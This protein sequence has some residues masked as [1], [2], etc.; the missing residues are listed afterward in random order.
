MTYKL[1]LRK[2]LSLVVVT[3]LAFSFTSVATAETDEKQT[4]ASADALYSEDVYNQKGNMSETKYEQLAED[5]NAQLKECKEEVD[6][7]KYGLEN[8]EE[9]SNLIRNILSGEL[10][11]CFHIS[12]QFSI[13]AVG[14]YIASIVPQY[15]YTKSQY[16][17]MLRE[18]ETKA[19]ELLSGIKD[20]DSLT[21]EEKLLIIH[22]RIA[23]NC[24][25]DPTPNQADIPH[26]SH[27][28]YGVLG[29][30][31]A[32]CQGY[33]LTYGYLLDKIGIEN[34]YCNSIE[35]KHA[36]NIVYI[37]GI[38]YHVDVTWDDPVGVSVGSVYHNNFLVSTDT[39]RENDHNATDFDSTPTDTK[40]DNY[41]WQ[42]I[43]T[44]FVLAGNDIYYLD[45]KDAK[46]K[47]M[48]DN[49][50]VVSV[51][52]KWRLD[53]YKFWQGNFS[54]LATDG[55]DL[56]YNLSDAVY[57]YRLSTGT[58]RRIYSANLNEGE[59]IFGFA[60]EG[61][62]MVIEV[63][64]HPGYQWATKVETIRVPYSPANPDKPDYAPGDINDDGFVDNEDIVTLSQYMAGW[65]V[66]CNQSALD[67]NG[68]DSIDLKDVIHLAKVVAEWEGYV[69]H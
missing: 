39:L 16:D 2:I 4:V 22:D 49:E 56:I 13:M 58:S 45:N 34:S 68:D 10:P 17:T 37:D 32:V 52:D 62:E 8:N 6:I 42:D 14:N 41:F 64:N 12:G 31:V 25:Y 47:R 33:A 18:C 5:I 29:L 61:D 54:L 57:R 35:L 7:E 43:Q 51:E 3:A 53:D 9:N 48:T 69:A 1:F 60:I 11:E 63:A 65:E 50:A 67:V 21:T 44:A 66:Y 46:V 26:I 20:N 59:N 19:E 23:L 24:M 30:G 38:P 28:I 27:T 15:E 55:T 40:Y 36:W